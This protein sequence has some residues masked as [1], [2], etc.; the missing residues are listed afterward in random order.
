MYGN[1][2][3]LATHIQQQFKNTRSGTLN[4]KL[5]WDFTEWSWNL[6]PIDRNKIYIESIAVTYITQTLI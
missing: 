3:L 2:L 6:E 5:W 4:V 1:A